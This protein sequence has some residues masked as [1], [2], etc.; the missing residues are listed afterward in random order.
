LD[1]LLR[2][3]V[4]KQ[5]MK[6]RSSWKLNDEEL[7]GPNFEPKDKEIHVLMELPQHQ[8]DLCTRAASVNLI[9]D[10]SMPA[11]DI[12]DKSEKR[13]ALI[14][15]LQKNGPRIS[16][17]GRENQI[18]DIAKNVLCSNSVKTSVGILCATRGMGKTTLLKALVDPEDSM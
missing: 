16:L 17:L 15:G 6:M 10:T 8:T 14:N 5:Y 2:G 11:F 4:D 13:T 18:E 7:L 1:A 12:F 9:H 3:D